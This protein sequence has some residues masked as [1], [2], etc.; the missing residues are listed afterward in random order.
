MMRSITGASK[1]AL[2]CI[3]SNCGDREANVSMALDWLTGILTEQRHS[4]IYF[5][6]DCHGGERKY[7]NAVILGRTSLTPDELESTCK[8]YEAA[9]G[10][11]A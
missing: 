4:P 10:R 6:P 5:T 9:C 11:N 2:F 1:E 7:M 3:G 8:E